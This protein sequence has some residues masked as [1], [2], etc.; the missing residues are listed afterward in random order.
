MLLADIHALDRAVRFGEEARWQVPTISF[1]IDG[2]LA[3][4]IQPILD[5]AL[6][7]GA[8]NVHSS[9]SWRDV[10]CYGECYGCCD[11]CVCFSR[12]AH[13]Y[14]APLSREE[15][16]DAYL[17]AVQNGNFWRQLAPFSTTDLQY[18][19]DQ[20]HAGR[21]AALFISSRQAAGPRDFYAD[22][23][24]QTIG[25][26]HDHD[27]SHF[28]GLKFTEGA[29]VSEY[30]I[31]RRPDYHLEDEYR[32][33]MAARDAGIEAFLIDRP[34]N[35][36]LPCSY[37]VGSIMEFLWT[38]VPNRNDDEEVRFSEDSELVFHTT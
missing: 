34:W 20:M 6:I 28:L 11:S 35:A 1:K 4:H 38:V 13:T 9:Y 25:W 12:I 24:T 33:V 16:F 3:N 26:L 17:T 30:L 14:P 2:V 8:R 27:L 37:R 32:E 22:P 19:S 23:R 31:E 18:L 7:S 15:Y 29:R 36:K 21:F 10:T 5:H